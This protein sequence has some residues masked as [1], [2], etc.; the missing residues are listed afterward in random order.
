MTVDGPGTIAGA[1]LVLDLAPRSSSETGPDERGQDR[2]S[3]ERGLVID[4]IVG[5][6]LLLI[7]DVA[8][9]ID[10]VADDP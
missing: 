6:A 8:Q 4:A 1:A 3:D 5:H 9:L 2:G 10:R 7:S